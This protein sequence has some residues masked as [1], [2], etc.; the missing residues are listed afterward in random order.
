MLALQTAVEIGQEGNDLRRICGIVL[1]VWFTILCISG[2]SLK[3]ESR[4][5]PVAM[6]HC[7]V[8]SLEVLSPP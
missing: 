7:N 5:L 3:T 4:R 2:I 6:G 1:N 8:S